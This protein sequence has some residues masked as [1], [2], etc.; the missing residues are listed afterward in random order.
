MKKILFM[1][2]ALVLVLAV[3][4]L[5][6]DYVIW[7]HPP[8]NGTQNAYVFSDSDLDIY[9]T[10]GTAQY[11]FDI[12]TGAITITGGITVAGDITGATGGFKMPLV[13]A[14]SEVGVSLSSNMPIAGSIQLASGA[15]DSSYNYEVVLPWAGSVMGVAMMS[16]AAVTAGSAH[17]E[18]VT[19]TCGTEATGT[20]LQ[21]RLDNA[22]GQ[23]T[24]NS[25]TQAM[26]TDTFTAGQCLWAH[27]ATSSG[28]APTQ[29]DITVI[30]Y[31]EQ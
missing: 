5:A 29:A 11:N 10:S 7:N 6:V 27:M 12:A 19:G 25:T 1:V 26:N 15:T 13:F 17:A 2:T 20:G 21:V 3:P 22:G 14:H 23:T 4:A 24:Y 16:D 30:V 9:N 18:V 28:F 31:V 8:P